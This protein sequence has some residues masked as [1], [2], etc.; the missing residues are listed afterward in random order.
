MVEFKY[1]D[2]DGRALFFVENDVF[3]KVLNGKGISVATAEG[4]KTLRFACPFCNVAQAPAGGK[5]EYFLPSDAHVFGLYRCSCCGEKSSSELARW[6][7][8]SIQQLAGKSLLI[9]NRSDVAIQEALEEILARSGQVF[10]SG[11]V[12]VVVVI[13]GGVAYLETATPS[14][15]KAIAFEQARSIRFDKK[16]KSFKECPLSD[17]IIRNLMTRVT[18]PH[19]RQVHRVVAHPLPNREGNVNVDQIGYD[20]DSQLYYYFKPEDFDSLRSEVSHED[21]V[22]AYRRLENLLIEFNFEDACDRAAAVLLL[23]TAVMFPLL[24]ATPL[25]L[26][27][28]HDFGVGKTTLCSMAATLATLNLPTTI[29]LKENNDEATRELLS[30]LAVNRAEVL[31]VDNLR[32]KLPTNQ[33]LCSVLTGTPIS[34]RIVGSSEVTTTVSR[35]LILATGTDVYAQNDMIRRT[36]PIKIKKP[37]KSFENVD[38]AIFLR[39]QRSKYVCDVLIIEKWWRRKHSQSF[40]SVVLDSFADWSRNCLEPVRELSGQEPIQRTLQ[41]MAT[42]MPQKTANQLF[43][44]L[45]LQEF[46]SVV[47]TTKKVSAT[48]MPLKPEVLQVVTEL[49][50]VANSELNARKL[51]RWLRRHAGERV[52]VPVH[53]LTKKENSNPAH[54]FFRK[55]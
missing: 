18:H 46:G 30:M 9:M 12:V 34:G 10:L 2:D 33:M 22:A 44:E 52:G 5:A 47:F 28:S 35:T 7:K 27:T 37:V 15:L 32:S 23:V 36:L 31:I 13:A 17:R 43:L 39:E 50:V 20:N 8:V 3:R 24:P 19:L 6:A 25:F 54:F 41:N 16:T 53:E 38:I 51:G 1:R 4:E 29:S 49:D 55:I 26:V 40:V 11:R 21:A 14:E 45:L 48:L 42:L